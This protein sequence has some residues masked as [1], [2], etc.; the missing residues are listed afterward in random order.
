MA[1]RDDLDRLLDAAL[2]AY[3]DP[4]PNLAPRIFAHVSAASSARTRRTRWFWTA[5]LALASAAILLLVLAPW[6]APV[7]QP[8]PLPQTEARTTPPELPTHAAPPLAQHR[9]LVS[10]PHAASIPPAP[11]QDTF[12]APRPLSTEEETLARLVAESSTDQR[13]DLLARQ[14]RTAEPIHISAISIPPISSPSEGKE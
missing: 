10:R 6:R 1:E 5:G 9:V 14:Q 13:E 3:A 12:L 2:S 7:P 8:A 11:Q 4:E